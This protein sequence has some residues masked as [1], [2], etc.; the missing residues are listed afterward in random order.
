M[1]QSIIAPPQGPEEWGVGRK[2]MEELEQV[3]KGISNGTTPK[4]HSLW[5]REKRG[6]DHQRKNP[7]KAPKQ[8]GL[9]G[10]L[11]VDNLSTNRERSQKGRGKIS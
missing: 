10:T 4:L 11:I 3:K 5:F 7:S 1:K 2:K 8:T 9:K 6:K